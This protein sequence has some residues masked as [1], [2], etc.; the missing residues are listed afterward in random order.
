MELVRPSE[1]PPQTAQK[2]TSAPLLGA[3]LFRPA[4]PF[5]HGSGRPEQR[6][7]TRGDIF[8]GRETCLEC[9][10]CG[11]RRCLANSPSF[12]A[13][14]V[15]CAEHE[16]ATRYEELGTSHTD[17]QGQVRRRHSFPCRPRPARSAATTTG[18]FDPHGCPAPVAGLHGVEGLELHDRDVVAIPETS[19]ALPA[20]ARQRHHCPSTGR[21]LRRQ[22][23]ASACSV[24]RT[25]TGRDVLRDRGR[26]GGRA[27]VTRGRRAPDPRGTKPIGVVRDM[28]VS[29]GGRVTMDC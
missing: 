16:S 2:N 5:G 7:G 1:A 13:E 28:P 11:L 20:L 14:L 27:E 29:R 6:R 22:P 17:G 25:D 19:M 9:H 8:C 24:L 4:P 21:V 12:R 3:V 10:D 15:F 18:F 23:G 26:G